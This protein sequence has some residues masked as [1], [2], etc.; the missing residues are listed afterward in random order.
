MPGV[1]GFTLK[2]DALYKVSVVSRIDT[3]DQGHFKGRKKQDIISGLSVSFYSILAGRSFLLL[4]SLSFTPYFHYLS[5]IQQ[6]IIK[7]FNLHIVTCHCVYWGIDDTEFVLNFS[8]LPTFW[9][10]MDPTDFYRHVE[11]I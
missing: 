4:L 9:L 3:Q 8:I 10:Y 7:F 11:S 1:D 2:V 5:P 6:R